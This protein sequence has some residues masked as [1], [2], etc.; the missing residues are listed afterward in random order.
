MIPVPTETLKVLFDTAVNSMDF[1]SGFLDHEEVAHLRKVAVLLGL[2]PK[3]ATPYEMGN[4]DW[5]EVF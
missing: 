5:K 1:T 4:H 2:D 3:V